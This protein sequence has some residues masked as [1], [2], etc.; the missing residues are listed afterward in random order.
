MQVAIGIRSYQAAHGYYPVQLHGTDGS[1]IVNEDNDRRLSYLVGVLPYIGQVNL[2]D[3][4][5][6]KVKRVDPPAGGGLG[7]MDS[8]E[9]LDADGDELQSEDEA[10][11]VRFWP[12]NGP[13]PFADGYPGWRTEV[14]TFRCPS[15]PGSGSYSS[16]GRS[17]G[18]SN[19]AA[20]L[21]D[22]CVAQE[23]GPY[24]SVDGV[25]VFD[26]DLAKQTNA[27]M[28]GAFV[29]RVPTRDSDITDGISYTLLL[30]EVCTSLV[31]KA[32]VPDQRLP[33]TRNSCLLIPVWPVR[34]TI[35]AVRPVSV[36]HTGLLLSV[37]YSGRSAT[38]GQRRME[39]K[40]RTRAELG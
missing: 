36:D 5:G 39:R 7:F 26:E 16:S 38:H 2:A 15:D 29:P 18:R 22:G 11:E 37:G 19:Y 20:C 28:R 3:M 35:D 9:V 6:G 32:C 4:I 25:F 17:T 40:S 14:P 12:R 33:R 10:V 1:V 27:A 21:G 30:G 23:T 31:I 13:E 24:K 8:S 34:W